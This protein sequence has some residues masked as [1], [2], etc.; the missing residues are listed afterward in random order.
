MCC[1]WLLSFS[2]LHNLP[3]RVLFAYLL[4]QCPP[5][6]CVDAGYENGF[7]NCSC[8]VTCNYTYNCFV[9]I[10]HQGPSGK[11]EVSCAAPAA[12]YPPIRPLAAAELPGT[13]GVDVRIRSGGDVLIDRVLQGS[14]AYLAGLR[15][16]DRL[17]SINEV[18]AASL[19]YSRII[20]MDPGKS[21]RV[22]VTRKGQAL[23][24]NMI[25]VRLDYLNAATTNADAGERGNALGGY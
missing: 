25:A 18:R 17:D 20:K 11:E 12:I 15:P 1:I 2:V 8:L 3:T 10:V 14:P 5:N 22:T 23:K 4:T 19:P 13:I 7:I 16:G 9:S 6:L 24:Y 21:V